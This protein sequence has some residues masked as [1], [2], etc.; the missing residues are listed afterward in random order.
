MVGELAGR[1]RRAAPAGGCGGETDAAG[2]GAESPAD[3]ASR[4]AAPPPAAA[5]GSFA[6]LR[7]AATS[8]GFFTS[9]IRATASRRRGA[10][11]GGSAR[12]WSVQ[13]RRRTSVG[14]D[15]EDLD[16]RGLHRRAGS[17]D[18]GRHPRAP[19]TPPAGHLLAEALA[20]EL[21]HVAAVASLE[22]AMRRTVV[23]M[24][25][26]RA[27]GSPGRPSTLATRCP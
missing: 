17:E 25:A 24:A 1:R 15:A 11:G 14:T 13:R 2:P 19:R 22:P 20:H 6:C 18:E 7:H 16:V 4:R 10:G 8:V 27:S 3:A 21:R 23:A 26:P 9:A 5:G 12:R